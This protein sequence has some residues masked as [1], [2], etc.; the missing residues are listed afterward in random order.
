[1]SKEF[2][3][4]GETLKLTKVNNEL[5]HI[6]YPDRPLVSLMRNGGHNDYYECAIHHPNGDIETGGRYSVELDSRDILKELIG[7]L[8]YQWVDS[9]K[10][11]EDSANIGGQDV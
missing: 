5:V 3:I 8:V 6:E 11:L 4:A 10:F 9:D 2:E 7:L 1:M